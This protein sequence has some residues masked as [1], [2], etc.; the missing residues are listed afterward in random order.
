MVGMATAAVVARATDV[1][2]SPLLWFGAFIASG[3]PD[4]D[5]T[6]AFFGLR[7]PRFHRNISHALPVLAAAVIGWW[8]LV[9]RLAG[10]GAPAVWWAWSGALLSHP[11]VDLLTTGPVGAARGYGIRLLWPFSTKRWF[12]AR[13]ILETPDFT[14]CR[15]VGDVWRGIRPELV[16]I[17]PVALIVLGA[18]VFA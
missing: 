17:A 11:V 2:G 7:G 5:M 18:A 16:R 6:L 14:A 9:T 13:P 15:S 1:A 10:W 8:F 3:V 12:L 4:L